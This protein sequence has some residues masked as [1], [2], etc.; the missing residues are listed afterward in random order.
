MSES[1]S[2]RWLHRFAWVTATVTLLLPVTTGAFVTT[3]DA[4]MV[5]ADWPSSDG[6]SMFTYPWLNSARDEFVEHGHR[7]SGTVV[8]MFCMALTALTWRLERGRL[9]RIL[10][11]CVLA[12]VVVQGL[13]GGARVLSDK[14][15][16]ALVHGDFAAVVFSLMGVLVLITGVRWSERGSVKNPAAGRLAVGLGAAVLVSVVIQYFLGSVLRHLALGWAWFSH[17]WFALV[18][19]TLAPLF[20]VAASRSGSTLLQRGA[21]RLLVLIAAQAS[22]GLATWYVRFGVPAWGVVAV[23]DSVAQVIVCSL[24]TI[25]GMLTLMT[26][27]LNVVCSVAV[28]PH[29]Q[30]AAV[31]SF[32]GSM[33]GA[34]T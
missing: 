18:P 9:A 14:R 8:G 2:S 1:Q 27:V 20:A 11:T 12:A 31:Q 24:H 25:V 19:V 6:Y 5:F 13:L 23:Q 28:Q 30:S 10:A 26:A 17:P 7:L 15:E 29:N 4:G 33:A 32:E 34:A 3:L 22:L 16:M 21:V